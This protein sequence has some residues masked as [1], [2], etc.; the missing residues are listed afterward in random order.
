MSY[1][2][3]CYDSLPR[4][5][6]AEP[7]GPKLEVNKISKAGGFRL[8]FLNW[9]SLVHG[10]VHVVRISPTNGPMPIWL[11]WSPFCVTAL[12]MA[13]SNQNSPLKLNS[14]ANSGHE[15]NRWSSWTQV[16]LLHW[17]CGACA[18]KKVVSSKVPSQTF[19]IDCSLLHISAV[20][21]WVLDLWGLLSVSF[22]F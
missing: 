6:E 20:T 11:S 8:S 18:E 14:Q 9:I 7:N 4:L 19:R 22:F 5:H 21:T 10:W 1:L 2:N 3:V 13:A 12:K 17:R 15:T 16:L